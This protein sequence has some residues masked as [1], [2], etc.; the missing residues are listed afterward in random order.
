[1]REVFFAPVPMALEVP[2]TLAFVGELQKR[3]VEFQP[4]PPE[5]SVNSR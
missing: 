2:A 1:M 3:V 5:P 4:V